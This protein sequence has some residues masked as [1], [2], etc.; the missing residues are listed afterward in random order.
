MMDEDVKGV[1][2]KKFP[3]R[4][5]D[6]KLFDALEHGNGNNEQDVSHRFKVEPDVEAAAN[7]AKGR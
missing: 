6:T 2:E 5:K 7:E 1:Y 3:Y 4:R